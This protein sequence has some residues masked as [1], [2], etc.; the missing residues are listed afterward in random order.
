MYG[1]YLEGYDL[2]DSD[3]NTTKL[4]YVTTFDS[5]DVGLEQLAYARVPGIYNWVG[6]ETIPDAV[7]QINFAGI[8][9]IFLKYQKKDT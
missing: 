4:E 3:G 6:S 5:K 7:I 1:N 8:E 2:K 9:I